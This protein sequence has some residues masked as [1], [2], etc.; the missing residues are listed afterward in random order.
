MKKFYGLITIAILCLSA[1][2]FTFEVN[3]QQTGSWPMFHGNPQHTGYTLTNGPSTNQTLWT[4]NTK[5][6]VLS[7]PAVAN[8]IVYFASSDKGYFDVSNNNL[9]AVNATTGTKLW[10]FSVGGNIFISPAVGDGTWSILG[11]TTTPFTL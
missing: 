4:Y 10:N 11:Q 6:W 1:F 9:N 7:S 3:A 8:G 2:L 5:G